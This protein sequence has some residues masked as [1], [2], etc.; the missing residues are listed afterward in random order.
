[1]L[2]A[3]VILVTY[4]LTVLR[5]RTVKIYFSFGSHFFGS[6]SFPSKCLISV[7]KSVS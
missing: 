6:A 3:E 4:Y 2:T 7:Q 1:V 5:V